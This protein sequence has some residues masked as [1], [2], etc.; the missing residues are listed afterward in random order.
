MVTLFQKPRLSKVN[1]RHLLD[2]LASSY[3]YSLEEAVLVE[4]IANS[5]DAASKHIGITIDAQNGIITIEDDGNGMSLEGFEAYHDLAESRKVRGRGIGFAGLGAKLAHVVATKVV[6]ETRTEGFRDASVWRFKGDDLEW[7]HARSRTLKS[8][9]TK[10]TLHIRA[11]RKSMLNTRVV[12][13]TIETH[14]RVLFD[15]FISQL[16]V[17]DSIYPQ[18][19]VFSINGEVISRIP[20]KESEDAQAVQELDIYTK[21]KKRI[22][23]AVFVLSRQPLP[24]EKQGIAVATFGKIIKRDFLNL[25]P[26]QPERMTGWFESPRLVECLTLD[27]Q[28]F[29]GSGRLGEKYRRIRRELQAACGAWLAEIGEARQP[30][31][32]RRAPRLLEQETAKILRRIPQLRYLFAKQIK[33]N[34]ASFDPSGGA[35][36]SLAEIGQQIRGEEPGTNGGQGVPVHPG[37]DEISAPMFNEN[38]EIQARV[39]RRNVR[40]GPH[41]QRVSDRDRD[42]ISWVEGDSVMINIGHS[43]YAKAES[44]RHLAYHERVAIYYALCLDAP[45]EADE[46]LHLFNRVLTEWGKS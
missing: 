21:G 42:E 37:A 15:P 36:A 44:Q 40:G 25:H 34:V 5:L 8:N 32:R 4:L 43:A 16:Y 18:G 7:K 9:G 2:D 20:L 11:E 33:E 19:I 24:E 39:R 13:E 3:T 35:Q 10:V 23:R 31:E 46:R 6:T 26:R 28:D 45:V 17:W 27:K 22:G 1:A 14:Y 12:R 41:I 38:G 30:E 29:L